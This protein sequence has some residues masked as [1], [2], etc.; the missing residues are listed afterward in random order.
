MVNAR[1]VMASKIWH[2]TEFVGIN[3]DALHICIIHLAIEDAAFLAT[4]TAQCAEQLYMALHASDF[5]LPHQSLFILVLPRHFQLRFK[6]NC[7]LGEH[8]FIKKSL[9][10]Q[11]IKTVVKNYKINLA[12]CSEVLYI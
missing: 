5:I 12:V 8:G 4:S 2:F 9:G 10:F 11:H 6:K 7:S 3:K 1:I